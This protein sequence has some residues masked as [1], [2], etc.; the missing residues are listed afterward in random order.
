MIL[1]VTQ[2]MGERRATTASRPLGCVAGQLPA[3]KWGKDEAGECVGGK[4]NG[5]SSRLS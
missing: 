3:T 1:V 4:V 2:D 5:N